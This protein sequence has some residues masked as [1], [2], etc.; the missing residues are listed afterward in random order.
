MR[1][2]KLFW[3]VVLYLQGFHYCSECKH[4]VR[5]KD[6]MHIY[7]SLLKIDGGEHK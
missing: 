6:H 7:Y 3:K 5:G 4:M 2:N 1:V